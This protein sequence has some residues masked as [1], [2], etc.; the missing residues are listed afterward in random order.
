MQFPRFET[1]KKV[2]IEMRLF[3]VGGSIK[4][5]RKQL[6]TSQKKFIQ[7]NSV[8]FHSTKGLK[9]LVPGLHILYDN[10]RCR[11]AETYNH[12]IAKSYLIVLL[13]R[14]FIWGKLFTY[15]YFS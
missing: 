1:L 11:I 13:Q 12:F 9:V 5:R 3:V 8:F 7:I 2:K 10:R 14:S 6:S 15:F 4:Y